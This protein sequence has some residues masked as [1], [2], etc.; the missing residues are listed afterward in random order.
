M[1]TFTHTTEATF[2]KRPDNLPF[3]ARLSERGGKFVVHIDE[4]LT[5]PDTMADFAKLATDMVSIT[6]GDK[7]VSVPEPVADYIRGRKLRSNQDQQTVLRG[8]GVSVLRGDA[9]AA[10][11]RVDMVSAMASVVGSAKSKDAAKRHN[12]RLDRIA[13]DG[14]TL[15]AEIDAAKTELGL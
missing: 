2:D 1:F 5:V 7:K 14:S 8:A 6:V 12:A 15:Q 10:W 9:L 3:E 4:M 13:A 11:S